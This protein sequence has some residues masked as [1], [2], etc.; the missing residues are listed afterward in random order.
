M[1]ALVTCTELP[2]ADADELL[3]VGA[4]RAHGLDAGVLAWDDPSV[5][6]GAA[7]LA[8][9]RATWNYHHRRDAF[10]AW[11][12]Q[13]GARTRLL[14][15]PGIVAWNS[16]K[17]YLRDL[18]RAGVGIAPT[19]WIDRGQTTITVRM[20]MR[21]SAASGSRANTISGLGTPGK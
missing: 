20:A 17:T 11:A 7:R 2:E 9:L 19:E 16:D 3:L 13:V 10:V 4:L 6:W 1:I 5:E 15:P 14:N 21:M 8:V 18:E 12:E